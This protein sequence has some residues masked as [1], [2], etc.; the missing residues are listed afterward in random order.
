MN[1]KRVPRTLISTGRSSNNVLRFATMRHWV[2]RAPRMK[3][4]INMPTLCQLSEL[5]GCGADVFADHAGHASKLA[6]VVKAALLAGKFCRQRGASA[7]GLDASE[8][9]VRAVL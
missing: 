1:S 9:F 2:F 5:D 3:K 6:F 7:N 4:R 8:E